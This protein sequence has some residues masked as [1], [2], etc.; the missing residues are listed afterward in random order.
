[1]IQVLI[2]QKRELFTWYGAQFLYDMVHQ[3]NVLSKDDAGAGITN[4]P[5]SV[6]TG[7][8]QITKENIDQFDSAR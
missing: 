2:G 4:I 6:N 7:L 5:Y 8:L 3:T 1:V